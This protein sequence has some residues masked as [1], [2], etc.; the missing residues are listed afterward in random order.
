LFYGEYGAGKT[1]LCGTATSVE[2]MNDV[3]M[4]SAEGGE[5]TLY[6]PNGAHPFERIDT[7]RVTNYATVARV[8]D[9]LKLH[10]QLRDDPSPAA[11]ERL[12]N[13]QN[14][15]IPGS[16][17]DRLRRYR[18]VITDSLTEVETY[19]MYQ[20]L[21]INDATKIDEESTAAGW[22]QFRQQHMMVQ[23]LIR[24]F[25]DLPMHVLFTAA[26]A[27]IQDENK[28][29]IY[30]PMM[31]GKLSGQVQGFMDVVGYLIIGQAADDQSIP[32]RR[33]YVQQGPRFAAKSRFSV[34]KQHYFDNP[35][36]ES[37]LTRVGLLRRDP[38]QEAAATS[39]PTAVKP[40]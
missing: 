21:G 4:I 12:R 2:E 39:T 29:Q 27:Y 40:S 15:I 38:K 25:R 16:E 18:T 36:M 7:V 14:M 37:I 33:L 35:T 30:S 22:D 34:Y 6:D 11:A 9:F 23:R 10:C 19:C 1:W 31:T 8:Y 5:L 13:L 32:P 28:R 17:N 20:L 3:L 26:R 24:N